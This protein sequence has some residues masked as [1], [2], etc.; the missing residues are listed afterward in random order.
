MIDPIAQYTH[1][2]GIAIVGG[3]VYRGSDIPELVGQYV[4]G[5]FF[6]PSSSSGRLF[7]LDEENQ[8]REFRLADRD[9][10]GVSVLGFS[11]DAAGELYLL[12]NE[13][14]TPFGDTGVVF[15]L[16]SS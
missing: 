9:T 15:K 7:Y 11:Q 14:G 3:F 6:H 4:F 2:E 5:D 12:G 10:P 8:I 1:D 16:T 13:T